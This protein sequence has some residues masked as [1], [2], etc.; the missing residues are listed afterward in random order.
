MF[1]RRRDPFDEVRPEG[2]PP[3]WRYAVEEA[4][5]HRQR[6]AELRSRIGEGPLRAR[7]DDLADRVDTGVL[8]VWHLVQ[9]GQVASDTVAAVDAR[10][11]AD[12]LKAARRRLAAA[13]ES[14]RDTTPLVAQVDALAGR[15]ASLQR[16]WNTVEDLDASLGLLNARLAA[17]V[18][19]TAELAIGSERDDALDRSRAELDET[20]REL[21]AIRHALD[22][23]S[24]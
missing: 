22:D 1:R 8:Y 4:L 2:A 12:E 11:A 23:L 10:L 24:C 15:H 3:R 14:G 13:E 20:V 7:L 17:V 18:A 16:L 19:Q 5:A 21:D 6:F 9:R